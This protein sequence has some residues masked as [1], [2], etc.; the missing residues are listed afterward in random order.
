MTGGTLLLPERGK[1]CFSSLST[2][3]PSALLGPERTRR[4][5]PLSQFALLATERARRTALLPRQS[6]VEIRERE[7][8]V[9]GTAFGA[10]VTSVR[11]AKRLVKA[12]PAGTNPI[13]FPDSI[14]GAAAAHV[15]LDLG[16]QGPSLT[17]VDG[18]DSAAS[19]LVVGARLIATGRAERVHVVAGD[20]LD[21]VFQ[22]ALTSDVG[23]EFGDAVAAWVLERAELRPAVQGT[24]AIDG[25]TSAFGV[26]DDGSGLAKEHSYFGGQADPAGVLD[27]AGA[28]LQARGPMG[29]A[30]DPWQP[31]GMTDFDGAP[32]EAPIPNGTYRALRF[33]P[34]VARR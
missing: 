20:V 34:V 18:R 19:A 15:A 2:I 16:L 9:V 26:R 6:S 13:D 24:V 28:W 30:D 10:T 29:S 5:D 21:E 12:G 8:V 27:V 32:A 11:Y 17:F 3:D 23:I 7:G 4:L 22:R 33:R 25:L 31:D 14:D 1:G